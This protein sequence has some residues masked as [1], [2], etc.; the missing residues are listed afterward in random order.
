MMPVL[1]V[2]HGSPMNAVE[3]NEVT[4][5]WKEMA[6]SFEKPEAVLCI[7][8][9]WYTSGTRVLSSA[10]PRTIH[11]FYGFPR[12]LHEI[13][14]PASGDDG[15]VNRVEELLGDAVTRDA[16][17]GLD[18]GAWSVL[19]HFY[20]A[21]DVPVVQLSIDANAS[22]AQLH[23]I[24]SR[25]APL[26]SEGVLILGS[27][28]VVHNLSLMDMSMNGGYP[29]AVEFDDYI[30]KAILEKRAD[31]VVSYQQ[32]GSSVH[33]AFRT[34]EHFD[35]LLVVIG[36]VRPQDEARIFNRLCFAGSVSMTSYLWDA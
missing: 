17:W 13:T 18:H 33:R 28:N 34:R 24:G 29:W 2:G 21:A 23:E 15:L 32:A 8:A 30:A 19:R 25:L 27:G 12:E 35:P 7:S 36:A 16:G 3:D 31:D 10:R 14:Y 11:D 22:A 4:C 20:P 9:H 5:G 1:F 26:R 6:V